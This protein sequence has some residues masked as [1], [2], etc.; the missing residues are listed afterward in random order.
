M[1]INIDSWHY[2]VVDFATS[3]AVP[4]DICR[5]MRYF[6]IGLLKGLVVTVVLTG[7]AIFFAM[8]VINPILFL[9][10]HFVPFLPT[11]WLDTESFF[12]SVTVMGMIAYLLVGVIGLGYLIRS[13]LTDANYITGKLLKKPPGLF[14]TYYKSLKQKTCIQLEFVDKDTASQ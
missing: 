9:I 5:Y 6:F 7:L 1:K 10:N 2:K 13:Y 8:L 12:G 4:G 3:D 11:A 14:R